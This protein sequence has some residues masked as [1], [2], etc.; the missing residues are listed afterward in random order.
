M[1]QALQRGAVANAGNPGL[2]TEVAAVCAEREVRDRRLDSRFL[3]TGQRLLHIFIVLINEPRREIPLRGDG[4]PG[5]ADLLPL[6]QIGPRLQAGDLFPGAGDCLLH[7]AENHG[8]VLPC[9]GP[10]VEGGP[11]EGRDHRGARIWGRDDVCQLQNPF[12][13]NG[14]LVG[15]DPADLLDHSHHVVDRINALVRIRGMA[16]HPL[17]FHNHLRAP[18]LADLDSGGRRFAND[19][20]VRLRQPG[21]LPGGDP[22]KTLLMNGA[23]HANLSGK[24]AAAVLGKVG[25]RRDHGRHA[26]LHIRC[27]PAVNPPLV[28]FAAKGVVGPLVGVDHIHIVNV[29]IQK[30]GLSRSAAPHPA[31]YAAVPVDEHLVETILFHLALHQLGHFPFLPGGTGDSNSLLAKRNQPL[32]SVHVS[33]PFSTSVI[34]YMQYVIYH[35]FIMN[36]TLVEVNESPASPKDFYGTYQRP[37]A[38]LWNSPRK[39]REDPDSLRVLSL[40]L[41]SHLYFVRTSCPDSPPTPWIMP[42]TSRRLFSMEQSQWL[43]ISSFARAL[44]RAWMV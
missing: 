3:Q 36:R 20:K 33:A 29:A 16:A 6:C 23:G 28:D 39:H 30:D 38:I 31:Q 42:A 41:P 27:A 21:N 32:V 22:L 35:I 5:P 15:D 14:V 4:L 26:S 2:A 10:P 11:A 12:S 1:G 37:D 9:Q 17:C 34:L 19:D 8:L 44:S 7:L 25:N 43:R 13:Q 40:A 18:S 24:V